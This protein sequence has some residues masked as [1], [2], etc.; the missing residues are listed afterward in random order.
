MN[1]SVRSGALVVGGRGVG[2]VHIQALRQLPDVRVVAVA[3]A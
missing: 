3:S 2:A 1:R